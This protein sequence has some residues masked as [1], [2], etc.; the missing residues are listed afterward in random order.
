MKIKAGDKL[1]YIPT[2]NGARDGRYLTVVKVGRKWAQLDNSERRP[3]RIDVNTLWADGGN[4]SSPGRCYVSKEGYLAE[5]RA[6][7]LCRELARRIGYHPNDG[8]TI[9]DIQEAAK[10]LKIELPDV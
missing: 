4:Y 5:E 10:L 9:S 2:R 7:Y 3:L 8:V 6:N 1:Y